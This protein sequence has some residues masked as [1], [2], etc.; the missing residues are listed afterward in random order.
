MAKLARGL[1]LTMTVQVLFMVVLPN[2]VFQAMQPRAECGGIASI[3][4]AYYEYLHQD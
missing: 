3:Y 4:T 1:I 2:M